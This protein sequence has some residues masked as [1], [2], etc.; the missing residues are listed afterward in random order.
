VREHLFT[1]AEGVLLRDGAHGLTSRA[2]TAEAGCAKGVLH[3][4]FRDFDTFLAELIEDRIFRIE[5]QSDRLLDDA[6]TSTVEDNLA[7]AISE[8][9]NSVA[10]AMVGLLI[11][12]DDLR[13][14]VRKQRPSGI[15]VL[16]EGAAMIYGYLAAERDL[17]R[18][19]TESD[20]DTIVPILI[21]GAHLL[22]TGGDADPDSVRKLVAAVMA[23]T[24]VV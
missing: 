2:V 12:R 7:R 11:F 14:R 16:T 1:A 18:F 23:T 21:G 9:F 10:L 19:A 5:L 22:F 6:G 8:L 15:P 13:K 24:F 17:G 3:A 20:L 4:H